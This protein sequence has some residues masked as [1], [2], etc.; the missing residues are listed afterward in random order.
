MPDHAYRQ[1]FRPFLLWLFLPVITFAVFTS[2]HAQEE[3]SEWTGETVE[4][5]LVAPLSGG[6]DGT[7]SASAIARKY[8]FQPGKHIPE[9]G[10][11]IP[12]TSTSWKQ[13]TPNE[14]GT[15]EHSILDNGYAYTQLQSEEE[16]VL[17]TETKNNYFLFLNG[18]RYAGDIYGKR[19]VP[20]PLHLRPG[21]NHL[22]LRTIRKKFAFRTREPRSNV[23]VTDRD[24]TLPDAV[25]GQSLDAV[26]GVIVMNA[27]T[28]AMEDV[29]LKS[30]GEGVFRE[31]TRT[32]SYLPPASIRKV[33]MRVVLDEPVTDQETNELSLPVRARH[34]NAR[35][36]QTLTVRVRDR[37]QNRKITFRSD[38]DGSVQYYTL[39][40]PTNQ[41]DLNG[42]ASLVLTLHGASVKVDGSVGYTPKPDTYIVAPTNRRPFGF[43]WEDWGRANAMNVLE[44]VLDRHPIDRNRV[45]LTGHSMGGHGVWHIGVTYPGRFAALGPSA[46]W[47]SLFGYGS[48]NRSKKG[49]GAAELLWRCKGQSDTLS[50]KNNYKNLPIFMIHG[51]EDKNVPTKQSRVMAKKLKEFHSD[52]HYH[53]EEGADHWWNRENVPGAACVNLPALFDFFNRHRRNESPSELTFSTWNP[54]ISAS[55]QWVTIHQQNTLLDR[56]RIHAETVPNGG[57][58]T[59]STKNVQSFSVDPAPIQSKG[60]IKVKVNEEQKTV[61]W[62]GKDPLRF[63]K[64]DGG[65]TR[66]TGPISADQKRPA[67][68][69]PF[70][71]AFRRRFVLVYGTGGSEEMNRA[72]RGRAR[73]DAQVWWYRGNGGAKVIPDTR[74][75]P[76]DYQKRNIILYGNRDVNKAYEKVLSEVPVTIK[77][78]EISVKNRTFTG[79]DRSC[80]LVYPRKNSENNLVGVV[81]GTGPA[82]MR[83][84]ILTSY[85]RSGRQYPDLFV[86]GPG[87]NGN[88]QVLGAGIFGLDWQV[89]TGT[90]WFRDKGQK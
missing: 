48:R 5:W 63:R 65:W 22:F 8:L 67:R 27:T 35:D 31:T 66:Q 24:P 2:V 6:G 59:V 74:F 86:Y 44:R 49:K 52:Y 3:D 1:R 38:V 70:K 16:R 28:E 57:T 76:S 75:D 12:G 26:A 9:A 81:G 56:S 7:I 72:V 13:I 82:G 54:G 89:E 36:Q 77:Q 88:F 39:I 79:N 43:D 62:S 61:N 78:G 11:N 15:A 69:G 80:L 50:M 4:S 45:Y 85:I 32:I 19:Q 58:I 33:P 55:R 20:I 68:Y 29:K 40:P 18:N 25:R 30:G 84:S 64:S 34:G 23:M 83:S 71:R 60:S 51:S 53:E 46:G 37:N 73:S 47:I 90:F 42:Q 10:R 17:L 41:E 14:N 87:D 21:T